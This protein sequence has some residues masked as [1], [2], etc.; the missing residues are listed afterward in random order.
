MTTPTQHLCATGCGK[1]TTATICTDCTRQLV[2]DLRA[3]ATG[4]IL[5]IRVHH[6]L[7]DGKR[8]AYTRTD[9]RPSL[10]E[11]LVDT[12]VRKDHTGGQSIGAVSGAPSYEL[13][14]HRR[15]AKLKN[16]V[17]ADVA[18]WAREIARVNGRE[19]TATTVRAAAAWLAKEPKLIAAHPHAGQLAATM[20]KHVRAIKRVID[21]DPD[22]VYLGQCGAVTAP[23]V[24]CERDLYVPPGQPVTQC[25]ECGAI[26]DVSHRREFLLVAVDDQLATPPE[27]SKALSRLGQ[28]V[29]ENMIYGYAH[30]GKLDPHPPHPRDPRSRPRYRIGDVRAILATLNQEGTT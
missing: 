3:L 15:A 29:T 16:L 5:R 8:E 20:R 28:P 10:Y 30:R 23:D 26:W 2:T 6:R 17:D 21:R 13:T 11:L 7:V 1:A 24:V 18:T 4:G 27:I 14:F 12:L 22:N 25:P 19:L 9:S